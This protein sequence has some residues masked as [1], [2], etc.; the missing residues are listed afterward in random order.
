MMMSR[1][2]CMALNLFSETVMSWSLSLDCGWGSAGRVRAG[3]SC[4]LAV[5]THAVNREVTAR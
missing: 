4:E 2:S 3:S 5:P 1:I